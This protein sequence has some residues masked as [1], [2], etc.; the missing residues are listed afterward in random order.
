MK[1]PQHWWWLILKVSGANFRTKKVQNPI[2]P[3]GIIILKILIRAALRRTFADLGMVTCWFTVNEWTSTINCCNFHS[4][5]IKFLNFLDLNWNDHVL[6]TYVQFSGKH[7]DKLFLHVQ[8]FT[9]R[10]TP[11]S[12]NHFQRTI[13]GSVS[14]HSWKLN[15]FLCVLFFFAPEAFMHQEPLHFMPIKKTITDRKD[16]LT[17]YSNCSLRAKKLNLWRKTSEWC[18]E[19]NIHDYRH[20]RAF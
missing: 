16:N 2:Q 19:L 10:N 6:L 13:D 7:L 1:R 12:S 15:P 9:W 18:T 17:V 4:S 14:Y 20:T 8:L 3:I 11:F 5:I